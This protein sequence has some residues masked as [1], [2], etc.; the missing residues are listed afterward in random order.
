MKSPLF[1]LLRST[2]RQLSSGISEEEMIGSAHTIDRRSFLKTTAGAGILIGLGGPAMPAKWLANGPENPK[3]AIVGGG[4]S[5]LSAGYYLRR[6]QVKATIFEGDKRIGGRMKSARI[7]GNGTLNTEIG[8]EFI[9]TSHS[10]MMWFVRALNLEAQLID[11]E[12]DKFGIRD[13]IFIEGRHYTQKE[14]LAEL[15]PVYKRI[16]KDAKKSEGK[17]GPRLDSMSMAEYIDGLPVS[18]WVKMMFEAAFIG[19]NGLDAGN[20]SALNMIQVV[21]TT[22]NVFKP[23]GLS[24]ERF[25]IIGGN[26]QVPKKLAEMLEDQIKMEHKLLAIKEM[27]NGSIRL[28]FSNQGKTVEETFD[29]AIITLPFSVLREVDIQMEMSP[30]KKQVINELGYGTNSKFILE[31]GERAWRNT[32]YRGYLFNERIHNGWDSTQMQNNNAGT[33]TFTV[34]YGGERGKNAA[35]GAEQQQLEHILPALEGAFKGTQKALTGKMELAN[36][37]ANPFIKGSYSCFKPGQAIPF[38][39]VGAEPVRNLYFAGE[40]CSVDFWGFMNGAAQTGRQAAEALLA[41]MKK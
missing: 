3:I 19:E 40:H 30:L 20:Q 32:G 21:D 33:G 35:R 26:D 8:A 16:A 7:F 24:D 6:K 38:S 4:M 27:S 2:F 12:T 31:V 37:P 5:G 17:K 14:L 1:S 28:T 15:N 10:D 18:K 11:V 23:F 41:V 22:K 34:Y 36:W 39:G 25:K 29:T 9:D 13:A